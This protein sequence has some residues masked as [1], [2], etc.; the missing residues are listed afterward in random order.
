MP[1]WLLAAY[2]ASALAQ[3]GSVSQTI[4]ASPSPSPFAAINICASGS[5]GGTF[6]LTSSRSFADLYTNANGDYDNNRRC[7]YTVILPA[8][9]AMRLDFLRFRTEP[10]FVSSARPARAPQKHA[11]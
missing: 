10:S 1:L 5:N 4:T 11:P 8:S 2:L 9:T 3:S 6:S 7:R